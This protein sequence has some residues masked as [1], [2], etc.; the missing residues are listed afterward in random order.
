M[1]QFHAEKK[2]DLTLSVSYY[3]Y[4]VPFGVIEF[5]KN[6]NYKSLSEKPVKRILY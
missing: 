4:T 1:N 6:Y 3:S 5:D 2:Y